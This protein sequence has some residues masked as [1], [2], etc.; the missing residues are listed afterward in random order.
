VA[1]P[2]SKYDDGSVSLNCRYAYSG[3]TMNIKIAATAT[4]GIVALIAYPAAAHEVKRAE[5]S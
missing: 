3:T 4:V 5:Y 1:L 2:A